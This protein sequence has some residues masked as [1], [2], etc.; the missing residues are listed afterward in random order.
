MVK[1]DGSS[2]IDVSKLCNPNDLIFSFRNLAL[3]SK[4]IVVLAKIPGKA[5]LQLTAIIDMFNAD[6]NDFS[7]T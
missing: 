7:W 1:P 4:I 5:S 3:M 6:G 2:R